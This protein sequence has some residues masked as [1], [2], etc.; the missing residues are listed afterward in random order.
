MK[1]SRK[2]PKSLMKGESSKKPHKNLEKKSDESLKNKRDRGNESDDQSSPRGVFEVPGSGSD[3]DN[4]IN[5]RRSMSASAS[6]CSLKFDKKPPA[7]ATTGGCD[8]DGDRENSSTSVPAS[9]TAETVPWRNM[10]DNLKWKSFRRF[11]TGPLVAGYEHSRKSFMKKFGRNN[12]SEATINEFYMPKP[13]WRSFTYEELESATNGFSHDNLL[14]KGGHAEVYKGYLRDGQIVAVKKITKKEK[15][16]EDRVGDFLTELGII[17]HI[18]HPNAAR[19]IGFSSDNDLHLVLQFAPHGSL[20]TLLHGNEESVDWKIRFKI[21]IGIAEGLQYLHYDC[22]KRIIHRDITA[23]NILLTEDYQPQIS[24]FGL[25]KWLPEKW[26]QQVVSPIEGTFGYMA[27]EYFMHGVIHEKTDVFAFGVLLLELISGRRAVDSHRQSLVIWAKPLL[28][29][30][31]IKGL[32]DP[33]LENSYELIEVKRIILLASSCIHHMPEKRP[34]MKRVVQIL[35][36][37][38][39]IM[40]L[41]QKTFDGRAMILDACDLEGYTSTTYLN[42]LN[43][44]QELV[45]G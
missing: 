42:D 11:S 38:S 22:N 25:A 6:T 17:A 35:K 7:V 24:D 29:K 40:D 36:G 9:P 13:S 20:A 34:N 3:S 43:R 39:T 23:S 26:A 10:M 41:R 8:G 31:N 2:M 15:K 18:N 4:S 45:M 16:D 14:G 32:I 30:G 27:P 21:A 44:H 19:L 1:G 12:S 5:L 28:E 37:D 33:R